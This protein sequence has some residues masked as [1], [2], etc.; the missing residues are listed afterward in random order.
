VCR[1]ACAGAKTCPDGRTIVC[2][3]PCP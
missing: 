1:V 2:D 3:A